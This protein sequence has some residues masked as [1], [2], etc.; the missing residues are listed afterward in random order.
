MLSNFALGMRAWHI[1]HGHTWATNQGELCAVLEGATCLAPLTSKCPK[2]IPF[3]CNTLLL[4]LT[5]MD[6]RSP[7][8]AAIFACI[9]VTFYSISRL[10][11]FTVPSLKEFSPLTHVTPSHIS[12]LTDTNNF[13]VIAFH[14]P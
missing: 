11:K 1:L 2:R 14:L 9:V 5:Y 4:F 13:E 6:L 3:E 12:R 10:G 7:R 8:D